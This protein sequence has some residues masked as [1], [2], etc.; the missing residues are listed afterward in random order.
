MADFDLG[1]FRRDLARRTAEA[2]QELRR[3]I[4]S[5]RLYAFALFTSGEAGYAFVRASANTEE[6]LA[7][8]ADRMAEA[9]TRFHGEAGRRL[10]RW[11]A[12]EWAY[13]D[14][15]EGVRAVALP[16]PAGRR[17]TLDAAIYQTFVGALKAVD[18]A[19]LFGR[20]AERAFLTVNV[21]CEHPSPAFFR[22]GLARLNPVPT[23]DRHQHETAPVPFIRC[24]NRAPRRERMRI[25]L[26]LYEDLYME[27]KTAIAEEARARGFSPWEVEEELVKFGPKLVP[28]LVDMLEHYGFASAFDHNRGL[29]TREVWLAGSALFLARRIGLVAEREIARLQRLVGEFVERDRRLRVASTLAENTARVLHELRPRRFPPTVM[30]PLTYK[31]LNPE[32]Y[33]LRPRSDLLRAGR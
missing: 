1:G 12:P 8:R 28:R 5:Q 13:H 9:D 20:G 15:S 19:G 31:L 27:W 22:K 18:R 25:W 24:V 3:R 6:G 16:D 11:R 29:E 7:R 23:V 32:R 2:V 4:G 21:L 17:E 33:L 14:F 26:A 10:L 30:D